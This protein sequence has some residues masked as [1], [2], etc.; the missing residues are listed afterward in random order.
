MAVVA[1][2]AG[3]PRVGVALRYLDLI[4]VVVLAVPAIL[5]GAPAFGYLVGAVAWIIVRAIQIN[6]RRLTAGIADQHT[7]V[8]VRLFAAYGRIIVLAGAIILAGLAG[9]HKDGPTA[10]VVILV[11]YSVSFVV[12][13]KSGP[14]PA[15]GEE[16]R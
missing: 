1:Q 15:H 13:L 10:A 6:D 9:G 16:L 8:G 14:P 5:L 2:P 12:K 7:A 4:L 11:A 3:Q